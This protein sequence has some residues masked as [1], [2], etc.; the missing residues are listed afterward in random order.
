MTHTP[1]R[2]WSIWL[3]RA[4]FLFY[5]FALEVSSSLFT[6]SLMIA[7]HID[8]LEVSNLAASY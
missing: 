8:V 3:L 2:A 7:Y 1:L 4:L 5:M 6:G